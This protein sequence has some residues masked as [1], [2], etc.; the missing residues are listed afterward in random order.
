MCNSY[1]KFRTF[2]CLIGIAFYSLN[3]TVLA[4]DLVLVGALLVEA[5]PSLAIVHASSACLGPCRLGKVRN[6]WL[7]IVEYIS[8]LFSLHHDIHNLT[9][10]ILGMGEARG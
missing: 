10:G 1:R 8:Y 6:L 9:R 7:V 3:T 2:V 5:V 4:L